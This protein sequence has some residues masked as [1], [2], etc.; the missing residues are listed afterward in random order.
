MAMSRAVFVDTSRTARGGKR[1]KPHVCYDGKRIFKI[2]KLTKLKDY[3]EIFIDTLFPEIYDEILQL[4]RRGNKVYYLKDLTTLKRLRER[5]NLKK[6]DVV[7]ATLLSQIPKDC[8]RQLIETDLSIDLLIR[9]YE[10]LT[11]RIVTLKHWVNDGWN[12]GLRNVIKLMKKDKRSVAKKIIEAVSNNAVYRKACELFGIKRN[13]IELAILVAKLPLHLPLVRLRGLLGLF[14]GR[15]KGR[16]DHELRRHVGNFAVNLYLNA[17]R[18][19]NV[20]D[21]AK[22]IV[23]SLPNNQAI[24]RLELLTLKILRKAYFEAMR[25]LADE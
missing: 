21:E 7:D 8:F 5:N 14:P 6:N 22:E 4:L 20:L 1:R 17:K 18:F 24:F 13:S 3:D 23:N 15:N 9:K 16:Y 12:Y 2:S 25:P 11:K 10:L 19:P